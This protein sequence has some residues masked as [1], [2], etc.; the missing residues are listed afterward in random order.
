[1][2]ITKENDSASAKLMQAATTGRHFST[3]TISIRKAGAQPYLVYKLTDVMIS[4]YQMAGGGD[5]GRND[6]GMTLDFDKIEIVDH[7]QQTQETGV[8]RAGMV[9]RAAHLPPAGHE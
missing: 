8:E 2:H 6:E 4:R 3:V 7:S 1:M 5:G 9:P